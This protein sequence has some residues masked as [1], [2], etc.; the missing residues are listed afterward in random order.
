[1]IEAY[2]TNLGKYTEGTLIGEYLKLPATKEDVQALLTR[3]G[4][5]GVLYEEVFITDYETEVSGLRALLGEYESI[6]ELNYLASLLSELESWELAKFE[7]VLEVGEYTG[8][9]KDL[10]N[11]VQNLDCYEFLE[12]VVNEEDLGRYY[13]DEA[14]ICDIPDNVKPYFDY[15]AYGR[16]IALERGGVF[17]KR[18][19]I[20][21]NGDRFVEHYSGRDDITDEYRIFYYPEQS[22]KT[23]LKEKLEIYGVIAASQP[24]REKTNRTCEERV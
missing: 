6:D 24:T 17:T 7:A 15:E 23:S 4:I 19:Y 11:L 18:G 22:E 9:V 16:D 5:D 20:E 3:I 10:I 14:G 13:V 12:H 2:V 1:M 21:N 8:S